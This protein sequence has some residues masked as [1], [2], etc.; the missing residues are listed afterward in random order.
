M[1]KTQ[2]KEIFKSS[3]FPQKPY[4]Y[5]TCI[6]HV[7]FY[8]YAHGIS[9]SFLDSSGDFTYME[10]TIFQPHLNNEAFCIHVYAY[11]HVC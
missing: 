10:N 8:Y 6:P 1:D 5:I 7:R 9:F 11:M 4:W 2:G 3:S